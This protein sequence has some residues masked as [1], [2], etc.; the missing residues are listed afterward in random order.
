[1]GEVCCGCVTIAPPGRE[2]I[3][4]FPK[5]PSFAKMLC[6]KILLLISLLLFA[7]VGCVDG[8]FPRPEASAENGVTK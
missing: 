8:C 5:F 1:M 2:P 6:M 4:P 3:P 7:V